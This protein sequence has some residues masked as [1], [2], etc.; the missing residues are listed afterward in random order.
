MERSVMR[1]TERTA[2][3]ILKMRA[4]YVSGDFEAHWAFHI[5]QDQGRLTVRR[6]I[7]AS[8]EK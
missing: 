6:L 4:V 2:E 5:A 3:A 8:G 1:W 7:I